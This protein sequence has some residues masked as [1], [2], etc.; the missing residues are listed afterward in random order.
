MWI[1]ALDNGDD[2]ASVTLPLRYC[3]SLIQLNSHLG[4][5]GL[6]NFRLLWIVNDGLDGQTLP[7]TRMRELW[8]ASRRIKWKQP[9]NSMNTHFY[10]LRLVVD[11][12]KTAN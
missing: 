6:Q 5:S 1:R 10:V 9:L 12:L 3:H 7:S 4:R 11:L 2:G 8:E